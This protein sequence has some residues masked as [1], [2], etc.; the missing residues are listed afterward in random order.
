MDRQIQKS[1]RN[2]LTEDTSLQQQLNE[3]VA[4]ARNQ[5]PTDLLNV[6]LG[7]IEQLITS[8]AAE[9]ALKEGEQAPDFTLPDALGRTVTLSDLLKRGP[10]VIA[11][12][13]GAW[14]PYCNLQL[15]AYQQAFPQIQALGASLV[16]ISPQTPDHSL[17]LAEKQALT[18]AVLS[19]VGN[20]VARNCGLVFT[21]DEAV[22]AAHKQIGAD[23]PTYN[24]DES[25]ELPMPGT[26]LLDQSGTVRLA[27]VDPNFT[28]RLDP[29]V[30][31]A[32]LKKLSGKS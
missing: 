16:A 10:V 8:G 6:L 31:I 1:T 11:F 14:C 27:F 18:F 7:S 13:R 5:L 32:E 15:H 25:W 20:Q 21:M 4:Q 30:I 2:M 26:F 17:S 29:S 19:D 9:Q 24:G 23:L 28:H 22:R 12:Y 3:I